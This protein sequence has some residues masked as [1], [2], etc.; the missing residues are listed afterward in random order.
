MF[1]FLLNLL[2]TCTVHSSLTVYVVEAGPLTQVTVIRAKLEE[3]GCAEPWLVSIFSAPVSFLLGPS[4]ALV[5]RVTVRQSSANF[6]ICQTALQ[7]SS[8]HTTTEPD[9]LSHIAVR[10]Y[11]DFHL[12]PKTQVFTVC[13]YDQF[14]FTFS[15]WNFKYIEVCA[16][17]MNALTIDC[18][19]SGDA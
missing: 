6:P 17:V 14:F 2:L 19:L 16:A 5:S 10:Y 4:M 18:G 1:R 3:G 8:P 11:L 12:Y 15:V 7:V 13:K 9:P